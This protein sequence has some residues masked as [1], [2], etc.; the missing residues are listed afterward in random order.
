MFCFDFVSAHIAGGCQLVTG[1]RSAVLID[2]SLPFCA[3]ETV[4][5]IRKA[6]GSKRLENIFL[7]HSHYDHIAGLP[8]IRRAFPNAKVYA[9]PYTI[10]VLSRAG[11]VKKMEE[12]CLGTEK[13]FGKGFGCLPPLFSEMG[14][15]LPLEDG[16]TFPFDDGVMQV[17]FTPGHTKDSISIDFPDYEFFCPSE[18]LG[19]KRSDGQVQPCFLTG[20]QD[21]LNSIEKVRA[22]GK[23]QFVFNHAAQPCGKQENEIYLERAL[24]C[25]TESSGLVCR[26]YDEGK[27]FSGI[28]EGY[29][30]VYWS[31]AYRPFWPY[32]AYRLNSTA[33]I[34]TILKEL[35]G[36][37]HFSEE[38]N[39]KQI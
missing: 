9:H 32:E 20:M 15:I 21:A 18:T 37:P 5:N 34:N 8:Y 38:Q 12:L 33:A 17:L 22:L 28:F 2:A 10:W 6:L 23:R 25:I 31:E 36:E 13:L 4:K 27:D 7:S 11:A 29:S 3:E 1:D 16:Q 14:D 19:V 35:R 39:A 24:S 26:L 30:R